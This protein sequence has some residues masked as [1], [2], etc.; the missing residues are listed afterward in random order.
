MKGGVHLLCL[1]TGRSVRAMTPGKSAAVL[2]PKRQV[3]LHGR[4][5]CALIQW[6]PMFVSK[7]EEVGFQFK[8]L[9]VDLVAA[10]V[11]QANIAS[12]KR[13]AILPQDREM[14]L[15]TVPGVRRMPLL[16]E[17]RGTFGAVTVFP[18]RAM[19]DVSLFHR[20][21]IAYCSLSGH[22]AFPSTAARRL[23]RRSGDAAE[24]CLVASNSYRRVRRGVR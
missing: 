7:R 23:R 1:A 24:A 18:H 5:N 9:V 16:G 22:S 19:I 20:H 14:V 10:I 15:G 12:L 11:H 8:N 2:G 3:R 13:A 4:V 21:I 6:V 17:G